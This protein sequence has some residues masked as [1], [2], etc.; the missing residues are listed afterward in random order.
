MH[1]CIILGTNHHTIGP[2]EFIKWEQAIKSSKA[3]LDASPLSI[4]DT[5]VGNRKSKVEITNNNSAMMPFLPMPAACPPYFS[6]YSQY[7]PPLSSSYSPQLPPHTTISNST[8]YHSS[9]FPS[10][11][12]LTSS[13]IDFSASKGHNILGYMDWIIKCYPADVDALQDAKKKLID[14]YVNLDVLK[15]MTYEDSQHWNIK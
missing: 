8:P 11:Q 4:R 9:I 10:T 3:T 5:L 6:A 2:N 1:N 12:P 13:P 14:E 7:Y 15:T